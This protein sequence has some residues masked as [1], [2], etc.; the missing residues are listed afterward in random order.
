MTRPGVSTAGLR[1]GVARAAWF[2]ILWLVIS[3]ARL[4]DLAVGA[5]AAAMASWASLRLLPPGAWR[6]SPAALVQLLLRF[7][8]QS[9]VAG[10]DVARRALDPN[11]PLR[12]GFVSYKARLASGPPCNAYCALTGLMPGTLPAGSDESGALLVHCL[13]VGQPVI[14]ELSVDEALLTR[15]L[16]TGGDD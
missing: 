2:L 6:G 13:D 4:A 1:S 15:V 10:L 12:P 11:L 14:D 3:D 16:G 5:I 9:V 7:F 8:G